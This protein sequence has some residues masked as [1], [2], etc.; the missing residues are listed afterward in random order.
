[1]QRHGGQGHLIFKMNAL[2]DAP[3]IKLLYQASQAGVKV[4]LLVRG[5]CCLRPACRASARTFA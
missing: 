1:M 4:D 5:V 3:M 2:E